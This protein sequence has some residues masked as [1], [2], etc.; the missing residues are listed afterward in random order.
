MPDAGP[1]RPSTPAGVNHL[2][3]N[4]RDLEASHRF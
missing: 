2:V 4:V 1:T 3:L